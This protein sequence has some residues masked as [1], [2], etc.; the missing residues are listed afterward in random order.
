[1]RSGGNENYRDQQSE[2]QKTDII[3]FM[4]RNA[5]NAKT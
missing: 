5:T 1:M 4:E 3:P 2:M